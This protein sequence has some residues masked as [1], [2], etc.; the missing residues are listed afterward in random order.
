MRIVERKYRLV[1]RKKRPV[2]RNKGLAYVVVWK[3]AKRQEE[4]T[5]EEENSWIGEE[6]SVERKKK[7][8]D[9]H[10]KYLQVPDS[11]GVECAA[12]ERCQVCEQYHVPAAHREVRRW[13]KILIE[14]VR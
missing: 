14:V 10:F 3:F 11:G 13:Q 6:E 2:E 12:G 5:E 7:L 9:C 4:S 1:E 8:R